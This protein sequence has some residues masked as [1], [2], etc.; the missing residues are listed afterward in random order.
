MFLPCWLLFV[1]FSCVSNRI[2]GHSCFLRHTPRQFATTFST[3]ILAPTIIVVF[4]TLMIR[5][6]RACC[7]VPSFFLLLLALLRLP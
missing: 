4:V 5:A 7:G 3:R 2:V 6:L 1:F